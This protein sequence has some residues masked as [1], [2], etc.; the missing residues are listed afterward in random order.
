MCSAAVLRMGTPSARAS[1]FPEPAGTIAIGVPVNAR[2]R[3]TS[4]TLPSPPHAIT[5]VAPR[6]TAPRASSNRWPARSET[7]TSGTDATAD[8]DV[9]RLLGPATSGIAAEREARHRIDDDGNAHWRTQRADRRS[10]R[11]GANQT[12]SPAVR[13]PAMSIRQM[14]PFLSGRARRAP[15][16]RAASTPRSGSCP[17]HAIDFACDAS[18]RAPP[19]HQR[20]ACPARVLPSLQRMDAAAILPRGDPPSVVHAPVDWSGRCRW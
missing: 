15:I 7:R 3:D 12:S 20:L 16:R 4:L 14:P 10:S 5:R 19:S 9:H 8:E 18:A 1:P 6:S 17:T 13:D 11:G 2:A